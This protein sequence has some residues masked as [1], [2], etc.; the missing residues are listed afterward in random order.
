V[1]LRY[2]AEI[3][4]C[5]HNEVRICTRRRKRLFK[6]QQYSLASVDRITELFLINHFFDKSLMK[7]INVACSYAVEFHVCSCVHWQEKGDSALIGMP[8]DRVAET[9]VRL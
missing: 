8:A 6:F 1:N 7:I 4:A 9:R 3:L 5:V 2:R